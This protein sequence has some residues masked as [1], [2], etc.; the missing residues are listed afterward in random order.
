MAKMDVVLPDD[1][2]SQFKKILVV[3][4]LLKHM[5]EKNM[6]RK[7]FKLR[8]IISVRNLLKLKRL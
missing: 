3:L 1:V 4:E 6:K 5:L 7:N 8:M 2:M